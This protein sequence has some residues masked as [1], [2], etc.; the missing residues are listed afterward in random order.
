MP[1]HLNK[2]DMHLLDPP[3]DSLVNTMTSLDTQENYASNCMVIHLKTIF[4]HQLIML[5]QNLQLQ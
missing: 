1:L 5:E 2:S 4:A 3:R